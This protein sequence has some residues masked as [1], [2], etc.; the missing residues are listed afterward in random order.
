MSEYMNKVYEVEYI[1]K[2]KN[3]IED[4]K[5]NAFVEAE[6]IKNVCELFEV[7]Q[8]KA[9]RFGNLKYILISIKEVEMQI[10]TSQKIEQMKQL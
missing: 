4:K 2:Q 9:L 10:I 7:L 8:S 6:S 3:P 5:Y 1:V